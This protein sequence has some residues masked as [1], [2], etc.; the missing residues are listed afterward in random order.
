[1]EYSTGRQNAGGERRGLNMHKEKVSYRKATGLRRL[2]LKTRYNYY[3]R[4]AKKQRD[5]LLNCWYLLEAK[6]CLD[7]MV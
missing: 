1:M 3:M 4:K 2:V 7:K 6:R 5:S